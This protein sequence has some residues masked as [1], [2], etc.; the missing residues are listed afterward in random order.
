MCFD[1]KL[2]GF[3]SNSINSTF[4]PDA[5]IWNL[6]TLVQKEGREPIHPLMVISNRDP[7]LLKESA[8]RKLWRLYYFVFSGRSW[9]LA[10]LCCTDRRSIIMSQGHSGGLAE[11]EGVLHHFTRCCCCCCRLSLCFSNQ[12]KGKRTS[13]FSPLWITNRS[14][15]QLDH[16]GVSTSRWP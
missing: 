3:T 9:Q 10:H 2:S 5:D 4:V 6:L 7:L 13:G 1:P 16:Q 15:L 12:Q 11:S 14:R 8:V